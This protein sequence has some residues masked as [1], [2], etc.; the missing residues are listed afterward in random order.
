[1]TPETWRRVADLF[2]EAL[3]LPPEPRAA[4]LAALSPDDAAHR[5]V[6]EALLAASESDDAFLENPAVR[7]C[8]PHD[9]N[10]A[11]PPRLGPWSVGKEIGRG[12]MGTVYL[13]SRADAAY[14]QHAALKLVRADALT[15]DARRRFVRERQILARLSHPHIAHLLDGG[16]APDGRPFLVLEYVDGQPVTVY[17]DQT[18]L[19]VEKRLRLFLEVAA[20]VIYAHRNLVVHSD[21]K[22][23]NILV[24]PDGSP[25]LLDFG[26]AKLLSPDL[27]GDVTATVAALRVLTPEYASPEQIRGEPVTTLSDVYSLGVVLFEL[28]TGRRP[29]R[30]TSGSLRDIERVVGEVEPPVPSAVKPGLSR[31]LD[32][33]VLMAIRKEPERRYPSVERLAEDIANHLDGR[34]VLARTATAT[35]RVGRFVRRHKTAGAAAALVVLSLVGGTVASVHQARIAHGERAKAE[36][37]L[38]DLHKLSNALLFDIYGTVE[39]LPG[40][41]PAREALVKKALEYLGTLA[42]ESAGDPGLSRDLASAYQKVGEIQGHPY[43]ANLGDTAGCLASLRTALEMREK[44]LLRDPGNVG[45]ERDRNWGLDE[46]GVVLA[47]TGDVGGGLAT[48]QRAQE[49]R[50][51]LAAR[52]PDDPKIRREVAIS[53]LNVGDVL[54]MGGDRTAALASLTAARTMLEPLAHEQAGDQHAFRDVGMARGKVASLQSENG[55]LKGATAT[56]EASVADL[57]AWLGQHPHD[58]EVQRDLAITLNKIGGCRLEAGTPRPSVAAHREALAIVESLAAADPKDVRGLSDL[59]YTRVRLGIAL[60]AAGEVEAA[61]RSFAEAVAN[62]EAVLAASPKD[63][64]A[65]AELAN[66]LSEWGALLARRGD[67]AGARTK[68]ERARLISE[69]LVAEDRKTS[70]YRELKEK[71]ERQIATLGKAR[72]AER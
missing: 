10:V 24:T 45:L 52:F 15:W 62:A 53:A 21:I 64:F 8:P 36:K 12:G 7:F 58:A 14:E 9:D 29:L 25:K 69:A 2:H 71:T 47:W 27:A 43:F 49:S 23:S 19:S 35:Y 20:A 33:I 31:D 37:R 26:I 48:L 16:T 59:A 39:K 17:A 6:V 40:S 51:R 54:S 5:T 63:Y 34:P 4:Y 18:G 68:L 1:M 38:S 11:P 42:K 3:G 60:A 67:R 41:L 22:P 50:R 55:D 32:A 57:K 65:R 70:F 72:G 66:T 30:V 28:L 56:L 46:I 44:L 13:V 61:G